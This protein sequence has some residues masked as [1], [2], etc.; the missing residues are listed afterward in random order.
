MREDTSSPL[1]NIFYKTLEEETALGMIQE[2]PKVTYTNE[3]EAEENPEE[4]TTGEKEADLLLTAPPVL[5]IKEVLFD[6]DFLYVYGEPTEKGKQYCI[7]VEEIRINGENADFSS[8][9]PVLQYG[10][11]RSAVIHSEADIPTVFTLGG[12]REEEAG[13]LMISADGYGFC[14]DLRPFLVTKDFQATLSLKVRDAGQYQGKGKIL[15]SYLEGWGDRAYQKQNVTIEVKV[16][17]APEV[18]RDQMFE[19][20]EF[21]L[22]VTEGTVSVSGFSGEFHLYMNE[23]QQKRYL[24]YPH[25][26][27]HY[28]M[29]LVNEK[30]EVYLEWRVRASLEGISKGIIFSPQWPDVSLNDSHFTIRILEETLGYGGTVTGEKLYG[31]SLVELP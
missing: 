15:G 22:A 6:G 14:F 8:S 31:E 9:R 19:Y 26:G 17:E 25:P 30:G 21:C 11:D 29:E 4:G 20:E 7:R 16:S 13:N 1:I 27:K 10:S 5:E 18:I 12:K 24:E 2:K 28:R 3:G 23:E